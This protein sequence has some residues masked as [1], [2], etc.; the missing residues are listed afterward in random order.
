MIDTIIGAAV[1]VA[2]NDTDREWAVQRPSRSV[3]VVREAAVPPRG[4]E[5]FA[6]CVEQRESGGSPTAVNGS[7]GAAGL[8]QL[9]PAWRHG[10]PYVVRERLMQFGVGKRQAKA[11][12]VYLTGLGRIERWPSL[13]QRIVFAEV[14]EDGLWIHWTLPGSRCNGLVA[15]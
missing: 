14:I 1:E 2:T 8:F 9:M 11:V 10:A 5:A 7:S 13:Y 12:R 4:W 15:R 6:E 3:S